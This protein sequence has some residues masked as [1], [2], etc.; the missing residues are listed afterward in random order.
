M[1]PAGA[2]ALRVGAGSR[3]GLKTCLSDYAALEQANRFRRVLLPRLAGIEIMVKWLDRVVAF[4]TAFVF[5]TCWAVV[6]AA[7]AFLIEWLCER[8]FRQSAALF[9]G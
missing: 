8:R 7:A 2:F 3:A 9:R 1:S 6:M 4:Q 5:V